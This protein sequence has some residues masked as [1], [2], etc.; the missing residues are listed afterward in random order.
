[1]KSRSV[2]VAIVVMCTAV[3][4]LLSFSSSVNAA[5]DIPWARWFIELEFVNN[6]PVAT[7]TVEVGRDTPQGQRT[8]DIQETY[9]LICTETG[10][11]NITHNVAEFDGHSYLTCEMPIFQDL[12]GTL[13]EGKLKIDSTCTCKL[14]N[15]EADFAF[16]GSS[17]NPF[18]YMEGLQFAAPKPPIGPNA[19][20]ALTVDGVTA[21]SEL[22]TPNKQIQQGGGEF[23]QSGKGYEIRFQ[24]DGTALASSPASIVG[25]LEVPTNQNQFYI[26]FNPDSGE[27]LQGSLAYLFVDPGCV[28]HGGI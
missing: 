27:I 25:Q 24:V 4:A 22:F 16:S 13:T 8:V 5:P 20:Y 9:E 14:A 10:T 17:G 23:V 6:K 11:L 19:Q 12:V 1:M 21:V 18:F 3:L 26:G 2:L 7:M 28:G 15:G